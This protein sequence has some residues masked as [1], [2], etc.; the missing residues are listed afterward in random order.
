MARDPYLDKTGRHPL[1]ILLARFPWVLAFV[2]L[3]WNPS[4]YSA[5]SYAV[6]ALHSE[7]ALAATIV[8]MLIVFWMAAGY[9]I[10]RWINIGFAV[11]VG[12]AA[13]GMLILMAQVSSV[14][15]GSFRTV[16]LWL[17]L[18]AVAFTVTVAVC[19][20]DFANLR[21]RLGR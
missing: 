2:F 17:I 8:G 5:G 16:S 10:R 21:R 3:T 11:G 19:G 15:A 9:F 4:G 20:K 7:P 18:T 13:V 12:I 1:G 6:N 14:E